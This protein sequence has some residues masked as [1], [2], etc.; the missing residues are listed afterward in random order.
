MTKDTAKGG[1]RMKI[2]NTKNGD[3]VH[4]GFKFTPELF[5]TFFAVLIAIFIVDHKAI[6][7]GFKKGYAS[8]YQSRIDYEHGK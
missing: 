1:L 4:I 2:G 3:E 5:I 8:G 7:E 6:K